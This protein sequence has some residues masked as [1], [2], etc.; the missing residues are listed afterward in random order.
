MAHPAVDAEERLG[1]KLLAED[2]VFVETDSVRRPVAPEIPLRTAVPH[3]ADRLLPAVRLR[4]RV[5]LH[6]AT[7]GETHETRLQ[8]G[9]AFHEVL[10]EESARAVRVAGEERHA[11]EV[12]RP[13]P[14]R[15]ED[16]LRV[17]VCP[18]RLE[19]EAERLPLRPDAVDRTGGERLAERLERDV[20]APLHVAAQRDGKPVLRAV[21]HG[22]PEVAVVRDAAA[23]ERIDAAAVAVSPG[24]G[25]RGVALDRGM[26]NGAPVADRL[27]LPALHLPVLEA[28]VTDKL[29][30]HAAVERE[31][32]V[33]EEDAPHVLRDGEARLRRIDDDLV[34]PSV[35]DDLR[36]VLSGEEVRTVELHRHLVADN[37]HFKVV[38]ASGL[39][40][41]ES[42]RVEAARRRE[43]VRALRLDR[44]RRVHPAAVVRV[45]ALPGRPFAHVDDEPLLAGERAGLGLK[46]VVRPRLLAEHEGRVAGRDVLLAQYAVGNLPLAGLRAAGR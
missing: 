38:P 31:V 42:R 2:E 30:V 44:M 18:L 10:A 8:R 27:L 25:L 13:S 34:L 6:P 11:I 4:H 12:E 24:E 1:S 16:E 21:L 28:A 3:V 17:G 36:H 46:R 39:D 14:R 19:R 20:D 35:E 37:R 33:L 41:L 22:D 40:R 5:A 23:G 9:E 32:D 7:A 15:G 45:D 43:V 26:A 29:G